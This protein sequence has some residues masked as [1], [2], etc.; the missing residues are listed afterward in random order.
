MLMVQVMG[1]WKEAIGE[2]REVCVCDMCI[3][4]KFLSSWIMLALVLGLLHVELVLGLAHLEVDVCLDCKGISNSILSEV[5]GREVN[6]LTP[7]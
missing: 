2:L 6:Y 5:I 7:L 3:E 4:D 1:C